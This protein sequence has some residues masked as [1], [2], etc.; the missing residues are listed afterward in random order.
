MRLRVWWSDA[1][2]VIPLAGVLAGWGSAVAVTRLDDLLGPQLVGV[3]SASAAETML[4]AVGGSM[5]TFTG[6]V[7][8]VV[9]LMLQL[10]SSTY[11]PRTVSYFLRG[12]TVQA[13]LAVF[14]GT[15]V[16]SF[17]ALV[18]VGSGGRADFVP[19]ASVAVA[20]VALVVSLFG[21]LALI[22][23]VG[24]SLRVDGFLTS[25]GETA[26]H[27]VQQRPGPVPPGAGP[28]G[29]RPAARGQSRD[30]VEVETVR[31]AGS[32][33]QLVAVSLHRLA[34]TAARRGTEVE[35]LVRVG[36][37]VSVGS[38]VARLRG[39]SVDHRAVVRALLVRSERS[40]ALDP[41]Y[42]L[43]L[44]VDVGLR[45]LSPAVNDPTTA[46][47]S[48]D[49]IDG[50]LR[51]AAPLPQSQ[52]VLTPGAGRVVV[53]TV[54]WPDVVDLALLEILEA[55]LDS[56]QVTRR[57]T[58]LLSDLLE[59]LPPERSEPLRGHRR[60]LV[61]EVRRRVPGDE[62]GRWLAPDR[63]GLGGSR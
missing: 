12:R 13:V 23:T 31:Y 55:G 48:L 14:L 51:A 41:L 46:V 4:A 1:F 50:V 47:R 17:Q 7:F 40:L 43:R 5:V 62:H 6:F 3:L 35:L 21:F 29:D 59:D 38:A 28:R 60:R 30:A 63:Q 53:P 18:S 27:S 56:P 9:L 54:T 32:P 44:L 42:G 19:V 22:R 52:V 15:V 61:A 11:S 37:A 24:R 45:A 33:G 16:F 20:L 25:L 10:G 26:R 36:D 49:E 34:R 8:S 39:P 2:W 57:M 58:A